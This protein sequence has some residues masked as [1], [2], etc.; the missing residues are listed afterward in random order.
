M[1]KY[2]MILVWIF[3]GVCIAYYWPQV[4]TMTIGRINPK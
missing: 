1:G 2:L 3:I 4:T